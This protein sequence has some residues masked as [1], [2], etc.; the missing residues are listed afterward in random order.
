M[1][2]A[3]IHVVEEP[4]GEQQQHDGDDNGSQHDVK[5]DGRLL[6]LTGTSLQLTVLTGGLLQVEVE[7]TIVVALHLVVDSCISHAELFTDRGHKVGR[8]VDDRVGKR[9]L[10]IEER[11]LI[12]TNLTEA[13]GQCTIGTRRLIDIAIALEE[14]EGILCQITRQHIL[15]HI[16]R[17]MSVVIAASTHQELHRRHIVDN[18]PFPVFRH[19]QVFGKSLDSIRGEEGIVAFPGEQETAHQVVE[20]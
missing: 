20:L 8:L 1:A 5:L 10:E 2:M 6:I 7:V 11:R 15:I 14:I 19:H 9:L 4:Q 17:S 12:V 18:E 3:A 16:G 13:R